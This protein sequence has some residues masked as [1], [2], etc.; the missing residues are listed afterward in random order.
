MAMDLRCFF[1]GLSF[2]PFLAP[3]LWVGFAVCIHK[4]LL[5]TG[6]SLDSI[7]RNRPEPEPEAPKP[8]CPLVS[9]DLTE[10]GEICV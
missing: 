1:A 9:Q 10:V 8:P 7:P 2:F 3:S 4:L 5:W 6:V